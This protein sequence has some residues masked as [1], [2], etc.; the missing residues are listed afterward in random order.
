MLESPPDPPPTFSYDEVTPLLP[1]KAEDLYKRSGFTKPFL[2]AVEFQDAL[3]NKGYP[4]L[5]CA[6]EV[7]SVAKASR[8]AFHNIHQ[9]VHDFPLPDYSPLLD[10]ISH[11]IAPIPRRDQLSVLSKSLSL[12]F[13]AASDEE[14]PNPEMRQALVDLIGSLSAV[15]G[16]TRSSRA[17]PLDPPPTSPSQA[18][19]IPWDEDDAQPAPEPRSDEPALLAAPVAEATGAPLGLAP[20]K[21]KGKGKAKPLTATAP[22][23]SA[24]PS[25]ASPPHPPCPTSY[26]A[27][28]AQ[29]PKPKPVTRPSLVIS[30]RHATL[31]SNLKAQAQLQAPSLVEACNEVL[32]SDARHANVRI[33]AAKWAPSGNLVVFAGPDTNLTQLQSSHHIITSAIEAAL[34]EPTPLASHPNVKWSKL[35]IN[36]V[37]TGATEISPANTREECH[38]ALLHDNPS[39]RRLRITQ[40]PSWVRKPSEYK[41]HSASSLVV[42][43][44]DPDGSALSSLIAA[45]HL[46]GFGSQLTI[47]KWKNP[48][49]SPKKKHAS[50]IRRGLAKPLAPGPAAM[51]DKV[52]DM[53]MATPR[54][55]PPARPQPVP[56]LPSPPTTGST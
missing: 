17:R 43:F 8:W 29:Q 19:V 55:P 31:A 51:R 45:R 50:C 2:S 7:A 12:C 36:S 27:A 20:K 42:A 54:A 6:L 15:L 37:P 30:L 34:P 13:H 40:L 49:P 38:Q 48:P 18:T 9:V 53:T 25:K 26:A 24:L 28:M 4:P 35:L 47:R 39:Y 33:S 3:A 1:G 22:T 14:A 32:Q 10:V 5:R 11:A 21:G 23:P 16:S 41:P 44:E 52:P 46:Y 56:Q